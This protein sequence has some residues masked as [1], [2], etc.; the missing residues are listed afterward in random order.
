[1]ALGQSL[2]RGRHVT[3]D[4]R[5]VGKLVRPPEHRARAASKFAIANKAR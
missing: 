5:A 1:M 2:V 3:L 4:M